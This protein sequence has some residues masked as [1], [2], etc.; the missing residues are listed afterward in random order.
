MVPEVLVKD[1]YRIPLSAMYLPADRL[2]RRRVIENS[3]DALPHCLVRD[4]SANMQ[5]TAKQIRH[6]RINVQKICLYLK[7]FK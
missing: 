6:N 1:R 4:V 3:A 5:V 7:E 2:T